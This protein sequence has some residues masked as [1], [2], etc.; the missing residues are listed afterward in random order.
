MAT[1]NAPETDESDV[2]SL[3]ATSVWK[4][5]LAPDT[6]ARINCAVTAS[7]HELNPRLVELAP[8]EAWQSAHQLHTRDEFREL[9]SC[10]MHST[11]TILKFL[12]ISSREIELTGCWANVATRGASHAM[13]SHPNNY[14]SGVYYVQTSPGSDTINFHDPRPQAGVVRPPVTQLTGQ[15]VD[16]VVVNVTN[17]TLLMF[18]SYLGH[19]VSPSESNEQRISI[20]FNLMFSSFAEN[21]SKPM[22]EAT[23]L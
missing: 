15:N 1:S 22:W 3:F 21:L 7:L 14:L 16:Q 2:F 6:A 20:S 23:G 9:A 19:S 8:G 13:H 18:P 17:G 4:V 12:K 10:I 5:Q 11:G